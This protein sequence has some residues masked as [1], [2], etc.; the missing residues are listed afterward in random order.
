MPSGTASRGNA[1]RQAAPP[2]A[3]LEEGEG[4]TFRLGGAAFR[5][6]PLYPSRCGAALA[7]CHGPK[8]ISV[9]FNAATALREQERRRAHRWS[10]AAQ[11]PAVCV[12][13]GRAAR[14]ALH[15]LK[16]HSACRAGRLNRQAFCSL[17]HGFL[18]R[19]HARTSR[20]VKRR[21]AFHG[22]Q[23][24]G[25]VRRQTSFWTGHS[26]PATTQRLSLKTKGDTSWRGPKTL[27]AT[28]SRQCTPSLVYHTS[29]KLR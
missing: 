14:P 27:P 4:P 28:N 16:R 1:R 18:G 10:F 9:R 5:H 13:R 21:T 17:S 8:T 26:L 3:N 29:P 6:Q 19:R 23:S 12:C 22:C 25:S 15:L 7:L 2:V 20:G 11:Q 24:F